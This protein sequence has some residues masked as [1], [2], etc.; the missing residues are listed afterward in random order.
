MATVTKPIALDESLHTTEQTPRNVADVLAQELARIAGRQASD[1]NY[2]NTDSGLTADN[3]Q[4]AIDELKSDI[5]TVNDGTL[6]IQQNGETKGTFTANQSGNSTVNIET[7]TTDIQTAVDEFE[8]YNGGLLSECKVTLSP[9]QDLHG[10]DSPWVGG[11]GKNLFNP[12]A[13]T[14]TTDGVTFTNNG[15]GTYTLNGTA[16]A[17]IDFPIESFSVPTP[18]V[19]YKMVGCPSGLSSNAFLQIR[20][21]SWYDNGNGSIATTGDT[22]VHPVQIRVKN[23]ATFNNVVFKPM[24]SLDTT[25]TYADFEPY[26]NICPI[27]GHTQVDATRTGKNLVKFPQKTETSSGVAFTLNANGSVQIVGTASGGNAYFNIYNWSTFAN[28]VLFAFRGKT[29]KL[30]GGNNNIR[31]TIAYRK[32]SSSTPTEIHDTGNHPTITFPTDPTYQ[33]YVALR[34]TNGVTVN[35]TIIPMLLMPDETDTT[36][37]LYQGQTVTV[38]LGGTYY[39]GTLDVVSG[40]F[41]VTHGYKVFD[42]SETWNVTDA[43]RRV[44]SPVYDA[45]VITD[46]SKKADMWCNS[47]PTTTNLDTYLGNLGISL[48]NKRIF[49]SD[50]SGNMDVNAFK[51][52]LQ[53][54]P[55]QVAYPLATPL[56][57]QLSPT[58]VKALVGENHLSAPLDGQ[59]ITESKYKQTF[60]FDDV[61]AYIQSLS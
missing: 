4:N 29:L 11:A 46:S 61:I 33:I 58:M 17:D 48:E 35:E 22:S 10:Y 1:V 3:V 49:I 14:T 55:L 25:I 43:N 41:V 7:P 28:T 32:D 16:T 21:T 8:T 39:S 30:A 36:P 52:L 24:F 15:D 2:D 12:T 53:N 31:Y 6:T 54:N 9:I 19:Q 40:E 50:G 45:L 51:V 59:D 38:N 23:G 20:G 42:G 56:T 47:Y 34:V 37:E 5:P 57:N 44:T 13:L 18:N 60:T 27:S 26:E